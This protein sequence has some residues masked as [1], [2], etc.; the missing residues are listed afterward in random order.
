[1]DLFALA[2][3][4]HTMKLFSAPK[5]AYPAPADIALPD[6]WS[7]FETQHGPHLMVGVLRD[8][9]APLMG[10]PAYRHQAGI[11]L[12]LNRP[13]EDGM[14]DPAESEWIYRLEDTIQARLEEG[15]QS[16]LVAKWFVRGCRKLVFYTMDAKAMNRCVDEIARSGTRNQIQVA[17]N[18]DPGWKVLRTFVKAA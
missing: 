6:T 3:H 4:I 14:P 17:V 18:N 10:H 8:G 16:L 11:A 7:V 9:V 1:L 12:V 15:N 2:D 5:L 13:R